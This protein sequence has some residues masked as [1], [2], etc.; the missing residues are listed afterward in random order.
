MQIEKNRKENALANFTKF[1]KLEQIRRIGVCEK[2]QIDMIVGK[3]D[4][5]KNRT[6]VQKYL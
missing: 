1:Y 6:Y 2:P 5:C 4:R 3:R